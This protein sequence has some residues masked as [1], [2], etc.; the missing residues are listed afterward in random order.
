MFWFGKKIFQP[1]PLTVFA[2]LKPKFSAR[3]RKY[4][5]GGGGN[6]FPRKKSNSG[7]KQEIV[8]VYDFRIMGVAQNGGHFYAAQTFYFAQFCG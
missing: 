1:L 4:R 7:V 6:H 5:D 2:K 8:P 3:F